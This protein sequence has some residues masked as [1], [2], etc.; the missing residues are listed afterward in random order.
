MADL[1]GQQLGKYRLTALLGEGGFAQVYLGEHVYLKSLAAIKVLHTL[2]AQRDRQTFLSEAR[3]I[4]SLDHPNIVRVLDFDVAQDTP[5]LV[6]QFAPNGTLRQRH[7]P[8][9]PLLPDTILPYVRQ[10]AAALQYA[11]DRRLVHRDVKPDNLLLG[12]QNEALLSDF[13]IA[14][15]AQ[16]AQQQHPDRLSGTVAYMAPEQLERHP[17]P[18]SDQ[19]A[20]AVVIYE[21]LSGQLPF[22]GGTFLEVAY[23]QAKTPPPPLRQLV[24]ALSAEIVSVVMTALEKDPQRRFGSLRAFANAFEQACR[25]AAPSQRTTQ[26]DPLKTAPTL[27]TPFAAPAP[28]SPTP[29]VGPITPQ[30]YSTQVTPLYSGPVFP[31]PDFTSKPPRRYTRR[32]VLVALAG[33]TA[34]GAGVAVLAATHPFAATLSGAPPTTPMPSPTPTP[35]PLGTTRYVYTGHPNSVLTAEWSPDGKRIASGAADRTVQVWDALTGDHVLSYQGHTNTITDLSW[36]PDG[37][38]IASSSADDTVQ[39]WDAANGVLVHTYHGHAGLGINAVSWA[40]DGRHLAFGGYDGIIEVWDVVSGTQPLMT[41]RGHKAQIV[42]LAW[43]PDGTLIASGGGDRP[44]NPIDNSVQVWEAL[45]GI[46]MGVYT[47]H[48]DVIMGISW[49]PDG[50]RIVSASADATAQVWN[51]VTAALVFLY[52][53]HNDYVFSV[54]WSPDA[55][56]IASASQDKTVQVWDATNGMRPFTYGKH[57]R[58]V[59]TVRWSPDD[60]LLVSAGAD[61]GVRVWQGE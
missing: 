28:N 18:A 59:W 1:V 53:G 60:N 29:P 15:V 22:T 39:V 41:Y 46:Q 55:K 17:L 48:H 19:Y 5:F 31:P 36:S 23:K 33:L 11:H 42:A 50:R 45:T 47:G 26:A 49:A 34:A 10:V 7:A 9:I 8:G 54:S 30:T 25:P 4:A 44:P 52:T 3:L 20:L 13:G 32:G 21:W 40:P 57:T 27:L 51:V 38:Q 43:S 14:I 16:T 37:K 6:M 58:A 35:I 61:G 2:L 24:P 56:R 12:K